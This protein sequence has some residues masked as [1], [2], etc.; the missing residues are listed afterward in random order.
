[1]EEEKELTPAE[2]GL[3]ERIRGLAEAEGEGTRWGSAPTHPKGIAVETV[4]DDIR[5]FGIH[6]LTGILE[7]GLGRFRGKRLLKTK[8]FA[9]LYS[10]VSQTCISS[11]DNARTLYRQ[12]N[13]EVT[14]Y[15][16]AMVMPALQSARGEALL[17]EFRRRWEDFKIFTE[18]M[19]KLLMFMDKQ[20]S[21]IG[22]SGDPC[23]TFVSLQLFRDLVFHVRKSDITDII[24]D[25]VNR[26]RCGEAVDRRLLCSI[27]EMFGVMGCIDKLF[28][29][30]TRGIGGHATIRI[31]NIKQVLVFAKQQDEESRIY[32][33]DFET[34]F[35][36]NTEEFYSMR[37]T[38]WIAEDDTPEYLRKVC[39]PPLPL[40][41]IRVS[42]H[43]TRH[44]PSKPSTKKSS[45]CSR[46]ST[47]AP[48]PN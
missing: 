19:R 34:P 36:Q 14:T 3:F 40:V 42:P 46:T 27:I 16:D 47:P 22:S 48:R 8:V 25:L 37:A 29:M 4:I 18:W 11:E 23:I 41:P 35:L 24:Q 10:A 17:T 1:M 44:R 21:N 2:A 45:A 20:N 9:A 38:T 13:R 28:G 6:R 31:N 5:T 15:L 39:F 12:H 33:D 26:E 7:E 30:S 43:L 32:I